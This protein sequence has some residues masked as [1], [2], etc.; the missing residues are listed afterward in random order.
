MSTGTDLEPEFSVLTVC[1][2]NICRSPAVERLLAA[3]LGPTVSVGSAGTQAMVGQPVSPPMVPLVEAEGASTAGFAARQLTEQLIRPAGLVLAMTRAHRGAVVEIW[4]GAV[5]RT[6]TLREFAR[7]LEGVDPAALPTGS[8]AERLRAAIPLAAGQ[9]GRVKVA[10][11][12]DDVID[13]YRRGDETYA[14]SFA[15]LLPAVQTIARIIAG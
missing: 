5:R 9:R 4:P 8:V 13:P 15:Q 6:F 14:Q 1:T 11:A 7:L 10:P 12:D 3:S 2:G